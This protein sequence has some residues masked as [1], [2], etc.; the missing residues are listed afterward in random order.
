LVL[1]CD[2]KSQNQVLDRT[3]KSV[4]LFRVRLKTLTQ[5]DKRDGMTTLFAAVE[6]A[7]GK[8]MFGLPAAAPTSGMDHVI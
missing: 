6:L 1:W 8:I 7:Q 2:E 3:R 4:P 5:D